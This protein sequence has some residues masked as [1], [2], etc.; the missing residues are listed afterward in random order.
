MACRTMSD[1]EGRTWFCIG[2]NPEPWGV[3]P[4]GVGRRG[5]KVFPT[6]GQNAQLAAYQEAIREELG[7]GI[8]PIE[9]KQVVRFYFWRNQATYVTTTGLQHTKHIADATNMQKALEDALQG[10]LFENDRDT[11]DIRSV[12]VDQGPEVI[13]K[14]LFSVEPL[15]ER[16]PLAIPNEC[17]LIITQIDNDLTKRFNFTDNDW[18]PK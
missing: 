10:I 13:G 11:W 18:P 2:V 14:V 16:T 5:G 15:D 3:G 1:S 9:G 7:D 8:V 17:F 6:M 12:I 4:L